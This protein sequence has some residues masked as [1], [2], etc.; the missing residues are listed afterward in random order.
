[1]EIETFGVISDKHLLDVDPILY[2]RFSIVRLEFFDPSR[3]CCSFLIQ[4]I[5]WRHRTLTQLRKPCL[6][7]ASLA[8]RCQ[9]HVSLVNCRQ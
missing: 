9:Y 7:E 3:Y 5:C 8:H 1:M 2:L 6:P 4:I